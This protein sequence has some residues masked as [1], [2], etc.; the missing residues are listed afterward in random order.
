[1]A[2]LYHLKTNIYFRDR[3]DLLDKYSKPAHQPPSRP[4][5]LMKIEFTRVIS[6]ITCNH[7]PLYRKFFLTDLIRL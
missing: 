6:V 2:I 5:I 7:Q 3:P 1:M 4:Q